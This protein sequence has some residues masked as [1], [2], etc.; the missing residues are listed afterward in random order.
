[1]LDLWVA[2]YDSLAAQTP[3]KMAPKPADAV[4]ATHGGVTVANEAASGGGCAA[5]AVFK[6]KT[7]MLSVSGENLAILT[8]DNFMDAQS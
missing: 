2:K 4:S 6:S 3:K 8:E 1:L 7:A 5:L